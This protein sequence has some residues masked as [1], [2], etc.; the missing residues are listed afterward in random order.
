MSDRPN[1]YETLGV[2]K[3]AD[4]KQIRKAF[5][6]AAKKYHPDQYDKSAMSADEAKDKMQ[7]LTVAYETLKNDETRAKFDRGGW[8]AVD[9]NEIG[10]R[11][12]NGKGRVR[13][14]LRK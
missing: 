2:E 1:P 11:R 5:L 14:K 7:T 4:A 13:P 3:D 9:G 8:D 6:L 12:S 10:R